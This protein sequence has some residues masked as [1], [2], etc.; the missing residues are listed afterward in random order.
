[1][2]TVPDLIAFS[3]NRIQPEATPVNVL[4]LHVM[5]VCHMLSPLLQSWWMMIY[6]LPSLFRYTTMML[7]HC[8]FVNRML[9]YEECSIPVAF[10]F[11][12]IKL[13]E[14]DG[15]KDSIIFPFCFVIVCIEFIGPDRK[16]VKHKQVNCT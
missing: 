1:M 11:V 12:S 2:A 4:P 15:C 9:F 16:L 8:R 14:A 5:L 6:P 3:L 7:V 13:Y 10:L